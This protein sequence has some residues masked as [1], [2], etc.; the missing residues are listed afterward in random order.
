MSVSV[1]LL[2][3]LDD[4]N[5]AV[6]TPAGTAPNPASILAVIHDALCL[7]AAAVTNPPRRQREAPT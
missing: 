3:A 7:D 5:D 6:H 1:K 2:A 4:L